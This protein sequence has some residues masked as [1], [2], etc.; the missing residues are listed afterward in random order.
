MRLIVRTLVGPNGWYHEECL[1]ERGNGELTGPRRRCGRARRSR[2]RLRARGGAPPT[3]SSATPRAVGWR[4]CP[5]RPRRRA[6]TCR[7]R[8]S[9]AARAPRRV[10]APSPRGL[11]CCRRRRRGP[12]RRRRPTGDGGVAACERRGCEG[13]GEECGRAEQVKVGSVGRRCV[14]SNF[15]GHCLLRVAE[16][17]ARSVAT[18]AT[19]RPKGSGGRGPGY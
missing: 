8:G 5:P 19:W 3:S 17:H 11:C 18:H 14:I 1:K 10:R 13:E 15:Q 12:G 9:E 7:A 6:G 4:R 2:R 16:S